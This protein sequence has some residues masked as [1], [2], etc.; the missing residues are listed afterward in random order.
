[1]TAAEKSI[2]LAEKVARQIEKNEK[3][4]GETLIWMGEH[5]KT[6]EMFLA[7]KNGKE[8][9]IAAHC[10]ENGNITRLEEMPY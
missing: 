9:K 8:I 3:Y 7:V 5:R 6:V 1:M 2:C 10:D 4:E